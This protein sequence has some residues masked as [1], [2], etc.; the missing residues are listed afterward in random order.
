MRGAARQDWCLYAF[1]ALMLLA[2]V[3][4]WDATRNLRPRLEV[5]PPVPTEAAVK[6][7]SF[8]DE[9]FYFRYLS[10]Y[11]QNAGD[12]FGRFTAL[13]YYDYS[14]LSKWFHL[15][16]SLDSK[17]N[18]MPSMAA[19]YYSKTQNIPDAR[20]VVNYLYDHATR[21][22]EHK[23]WWLIQALY[24]AHHTLNDLD[25]ALKVAKPLSHPA[26]PVWAQQMVAVVHE[27]RGEMRDALTIMDTIRENVQQIP[28]ADLRFMTY[29]VEDR[30]KALDKK[31][32]APV[33]EKLKAQEQRDY[34]T[35]AASP[36]AP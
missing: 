14:K 29:F 34:S 7:L 15:L 17:S 12:T 2:Q 35:P 6:A 4:Y 32:R 36:A 3:F 24:I 33:L 13:R 20:Y 11:L 19:Y 10:L 18:M 25:L 8:G 30:L 26:V 31:E 28:E 5:V 21:D 16:D 9:Q 23:W 22:V 1:F 27:K